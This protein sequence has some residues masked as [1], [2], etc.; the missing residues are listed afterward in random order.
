MGKHEVI[1]ESG[2]GNYLVAKKPNAVANEFLYS[3][4]SALF[5]VDTIICDVHALEGEKR[6]ARE[7]YLA[8]ELFVQL[9]KDGIVKAQQFDNTFKGEVADKLSQA[10]QADYKRATEDALAPTSTIDPDNIEA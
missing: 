4:P 8:S 10:S 3:E 5:W 6:Y 2:F 7:G 1:I 9:S